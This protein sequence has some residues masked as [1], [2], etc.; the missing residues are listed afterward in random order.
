MSEADGKELFAPPKTAHMGRVRK[1]YKRLDNWVLELS[2][3]KHAILIGF[4]AALGSLGV[5]LALGDP[6]YAVAIG[7]GLSSIAFNYWSNPNQKEE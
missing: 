5:S 6:N 4:A 3:G 7:I 1:L 2:R